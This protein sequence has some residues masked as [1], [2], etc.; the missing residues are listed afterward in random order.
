[1]GAN[2]APQPHRLFAALPAAFASRFF[3]R[4][5]SSRRIGGFDCG[6][7]QPRIPQTRFNSDFSDN[8][9][10]DSVFSESGVDVI[11][12]LDVCRAATPCR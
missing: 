11:P 5:G 10:S 8:V 12:S 1:M 6:V 3:S 9:F 2:L 4:C 7:S